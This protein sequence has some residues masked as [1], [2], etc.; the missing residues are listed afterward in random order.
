MAAA[1][2]AAGVPRPTSARGRAALATVA[3]GR[4]RLVGNRAL[5]RRLLQ[6][7]AI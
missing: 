3:S 2:L 4:V 6:V 7:L 5:A 1:P